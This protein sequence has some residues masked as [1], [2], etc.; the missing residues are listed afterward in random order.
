MMIDYEELFEKYCYDRCP[1][2]NDKSEYYWYKYGTCLNCPA[3]D[4]SEYL[5]QVE[6]EHE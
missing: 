2:G 1:Y 3:E 6:G 5:N 4:F